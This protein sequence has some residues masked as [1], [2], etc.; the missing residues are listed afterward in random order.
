MQ[1]KIET[2]NGHRLGRRLDS[3]SIRWFVEWFFAPT[4]ASEKAPKLME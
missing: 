3:F 2:E 4:H 1:V